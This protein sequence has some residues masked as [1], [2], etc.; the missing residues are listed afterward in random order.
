MFHDILVVVH[1]IICFGLIGLVLIQHGKGADAGAAFGGGGGGG[2]SGTVFG[3]QGSGS[4]LTRTTAILAASFFVTCL[5]LAYFSM[6]KI[7]PKSI[8]ETQPIVTEQQKP[9]VSTDDETPIVPE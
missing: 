4:F 8:V 5:V 9:S 7:T 3:S 1:L 2:A 6:Q